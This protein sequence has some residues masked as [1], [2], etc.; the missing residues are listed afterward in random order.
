M[1][2]EQIYRQILAAYGDIWSKNLTMKM[3]KMAI[4]TTKWIFERSLTGQFFD[5]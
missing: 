3:P 5:G 2:L 1:I 4:L